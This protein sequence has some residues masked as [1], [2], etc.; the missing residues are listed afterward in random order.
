MS[1]SKIAVFVSHNLQDHKVAKSLVKEL[2]AHEINAYL[3]AKP[4]TEITEWQREV[5]ESIRA[6]DTIVIIVDPEHPSDWYQQFE[7]STALE[8]SWED[9]RK[10]FIPL[11]IE[12]AELPRFLSSEDKGLR[13]REIKKEWKHVVKKLIHIIQDETMTAGETLITEK[14]VYQQQ[15]A[16]LKTIK[17]A[18]QTLKQCKP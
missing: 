5:A 2:K 14:E 16:Q 11:L 15:R 12:N 6:A 1:N 3:A 10:R 18:V 8:A 7:W 17:K 4:A 9:K 13:V